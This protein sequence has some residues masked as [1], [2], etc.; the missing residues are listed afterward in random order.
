VKRRNQLKVHSCPEHL[1]IEN[2]SSQEVLRPHGTDKGGAKVKL[3]AD[4]NQITVAKKD[5]GCANVAWAGV[6]EIPGH[7]P[8]QLHV[9]PGSVLPHPP[10]PA[11][12]QLLRRP[13]VARVT[14][15]DCD[16]IWHSYSNPASPS[17]SR[18]RCRILPLRR[19]WS[20]TLSSLSLHALY[21][22][23]SNTQDWSARSSPSRPYADGLHRKE[24]APR[25]RHS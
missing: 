10:F 25:R 17:A 2:T 6:Q 14:Q 13:H 8:F 9:S 18:S 23:A 12:W 15:S 20:D 19:D 5:C 1:P 3:K 7:H 24:E 16:T 22:L 21:Y 4:T 11:V